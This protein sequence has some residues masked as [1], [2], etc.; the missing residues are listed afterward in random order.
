MPSFIVRRLNSRSPA[1]YTCRPMVPPLSVNKMTIVSSN[2]PLFFSHSSNRPNYRP[3]CNHGKKSAAPGP[4][5]S[6]YMSAY[7]SGG[8]SGI[9][10]TFVGR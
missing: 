4:T 10:A 7:F 3:G 8:Q 2:N 5:L 9:C 6:R 1:S